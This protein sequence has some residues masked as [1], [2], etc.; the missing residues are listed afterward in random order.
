MNLFNRDSSVSSN[1]YNLT[2]I[3]SNKITK[4]PKYFYVAT[5]HMSFHSMKQSF[6]PSQEEEKEEENIQERIGGHKTG[7]SR[8]L[9]QFLTPLD[10]LSYVNPSFARLYETRVNF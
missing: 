8:L 7:C 6:Y 1:I 4:L 10:S 9:I 5:H 2:S 3:S